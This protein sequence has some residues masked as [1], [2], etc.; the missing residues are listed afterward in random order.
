MLCTLSFCRPFAGAGMNAPINSVDITLALVDGCMRH[1]IN[2]DT[3]VRSVIIIMCYTF[4]CKWLAHESL[5]FEYKEYADENV[6]NLIGIHQL[7][8]RSLAYPFRMYCAE[9]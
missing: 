2:S 3:K 5:A 8:R 1:V 9:T 4:S 7:N 6:S